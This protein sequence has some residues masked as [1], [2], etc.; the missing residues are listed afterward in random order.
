MRTDKIIL[1]TDSGIGEGKCNDSYLKKRK[2][3]KKLQKLLYLVT[4]LLQLNHCNR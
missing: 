3:K 1:K 4:K 2:R